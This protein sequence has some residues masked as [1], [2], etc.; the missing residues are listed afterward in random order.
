MDLI[1]LGAFQVTSTGELRPKK[2]ETK[3]PARIKTVSLDL[4][5]DFRKG[6]MYGG[7]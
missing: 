3:A 6:K 1:T 2:A 7:E 4:G 5:D